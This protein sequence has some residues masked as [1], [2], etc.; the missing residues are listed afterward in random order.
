MSKVGDTGID[1]PNANVLIQVRAPL[2]TTQQSSAPRRWVYLPFFVY[3]CGSVVLLPLPLDTVALLFQSLMARAR[4]LCRSSIPQDIIA[5]WLSA[6]GGSAP[7]PDPASEEGETW[8]EARQSGI[9][10]HTSLQGHS[11]DVLFGQAATVSD[12]PGKLGS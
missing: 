9:L 11:R 12:R 10:L 1:L 6:A 8:D 3:V 2:D 5:R 4:G 7:R